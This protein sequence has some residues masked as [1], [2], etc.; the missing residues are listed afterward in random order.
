MAVQE[1]IG[2]ESNEKPKKAL[3][4]WSFEDKQNMK[5]LKMNSFPLELKDADKGLFTG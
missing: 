1:F 4:I 2:P 5:S 3:G